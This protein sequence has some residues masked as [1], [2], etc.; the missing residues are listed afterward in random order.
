MSAFSSLSDAALAEAIAR[1]ERGSGELEARLL[2]RAVAERDRRAAGRRPVRPRRLSPEE[3]RRAEDEERKQHV[4]WIG[5]AA[6]AQLE[7][8]RPSREAELFTGGSLAR[9][10]E[11]GGSL[12]G[13]HFRTKKNKSHR[14]AAVLWREIRAEKFRHR[15][16]GELGSGRL[17]P[18]GDKR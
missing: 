14:T 4:R 18:K 11:H 6:Q 7:G 16:E 12:E 17:N 3:R 1:Y 5:E 8:R 2:A 13:E 9:W 10:L 15:D